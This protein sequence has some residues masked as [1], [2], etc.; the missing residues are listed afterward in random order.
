MHGNTEIKL[1]T[2]C[3][4]A[5]TA[6]QFPARYRYCRQCPDLPS[7]FKSKDCVRLYPEYKAARSRTLTTHLHQIPSLRMRGAVP[8]L[9]H[10]SW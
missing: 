7:A 2:T 4:S 9:P 6:L 3:V 8:Q 10:A 1:Q 5:H